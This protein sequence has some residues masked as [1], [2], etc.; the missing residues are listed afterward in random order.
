M[1][2]KNLIHDD[3]IDLYRLFED[4][5][6][7]KWSIITITFLTTLFGTTYVLIQPNSYQVSTPIH[8]ANNS[9]FVKYK[10]LNYLISEIEKGLDMRGNQE[11]ITNVSESSLLSS[12]TLDSRSIFKLFISEFNTYEAMIDVLSKDEYVK[13]S[14]KGL[15]EA[16]KQRAL[17]QYA[18]LFKLKPPLEDEKNW[19]LS[20]VWVDPWRGSNLLNDAIKQILAN[21]QEM[22]KKNNDELALSIDTINSQS[23][24][25]LSN[26]VN[27]LKKKQIIRDS[28][29]IN[30][31]MEQASIAKELG[32][33][34]NTLD[35][36]TLRQSAQRAIS[37]NVT[38]ID[39]PYYLRGTTA[40]NTEIALI[41][42]RSTEASLLMSA[43][44]I[45]VNE[46]ILE[47]ENDLNSSQL[48]AFSDMVE[49]DDPNNWLI[50]NLDLAD[51]K[52]LKNSKAIIILSIFLGGMVGVIYVI[53]SNAY[54]MRK[55]QVR[56]S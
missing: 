48:R 49:N 20:F 13:Q 54:R 40:I 38:S 15:D 10:S 35:E 37:V 50:Y 53:I 52:S 24:E 28:K 56:K 25:V 16:D 29:H 1:S 2:K 19:L 4:L 21:A 32:I 18:K 44:Y 33:Y 41:E 46:D 27:L 3:E 11:Y 17:I 36:Y 8:S 14:I 34:A 6:N 51:I 45:K 5:W 55:N 30:Y 42:G 12:N 26:E 23:L 31:L 39:V 22:V 43:D 47:L 9:V 7:R